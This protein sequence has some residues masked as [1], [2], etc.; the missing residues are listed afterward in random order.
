[1]HTPE[2]QVL[3]TEML[4]QIQEVWPDELKPHAEKISSKIP[5]FFTPMV[6]KL[7]SNPL[8]LLDYLAENPKQKLTDKGRQTLDNF[9]RDK[10]L[11]RQIIGKVFKVVGM[12]V[13]ELSFEAICAIST[14]ASLEVRFWIELGT[15]ENVID[16]ENQLRYE[17]I[18]DAIGILDFMTGRIERIENDDSFEI[19]D[20]DLH[21]VFGVSKFM[22]E[23]MLI[24]VQELAEVDT[25]DFTEEKIDEKGGSAVKDFTPLMRQ[26]FLKLVA[27]FYSMQMHV[28]SAVSQQ[29]S[30]DKHILEMLKKSDGTG[31][32]YDW[33]LPL[34]CELQDGDHSSKFTAEASK[35]VLSKS[36]NKSDLSYFLK[37]LLQ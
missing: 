10:K 37:T 2:Y 20:D 26:P 25:R 36:E 24:I 28:D 15:H 1:V 17:T 9:C 23:C 32:V 11:N 33:F 19:G 21:K 5:D 7:E 18:L 16:V 13:D 29:A 34:M 31:V 6:V 22:N 27:R 35:I 14:R 3:A 12:Y 4:Y 8:K 30:F